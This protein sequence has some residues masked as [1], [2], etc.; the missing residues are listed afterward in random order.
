MT[1]NKYSEYKYSE[2]VTIRKPWE[3]SAFDKMVQK[4]VLVERKAK[5]E[6]KDQLDRIEEKLD[7]LL[8]PQLINGVWR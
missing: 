8:G 4:P 6:I 7:K 3:D 5:N 1:E 2:S